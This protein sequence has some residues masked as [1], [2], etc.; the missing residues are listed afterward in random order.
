MKKLAVTLSLAALATGAW[1]QG[2]VTINNSSFS[3]VTN[4]AAAG[5]GTGVTSKTAGAFLY[6]T[7]VNSSTV[8]TIDASL[9]GLT[10]AGW[11]DTGITGVNN[12]GIGGNGHIN[13]TATAGNGLNW[14]AGSYQSAI[15]V[16]WSSNL[17]ATWSAV[18]TA[19]QGATLSGGAWSG[20]TLAQGGFLGYSII[21]NGAAGNSTGAAAILFSSLTSAQVPTPINAGFSLFTTTSVPEPGTLAL[22]GLG[23]AALMIFRRRK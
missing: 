8:T 2:F 5:L 20:G 11:S 3:I 9:Q 13:G 23:A 10:A 15:V 22:A 6:D 18:Q 14:A 7:L 19:L 1:A 17:G 12:T 4:G 16:G 21:A